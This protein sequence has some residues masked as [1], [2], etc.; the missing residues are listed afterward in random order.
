MAYLKTESDKGEGKPPRLKVEAER[1][2]QKK[3][4]AKEYECRRA[5]H[6]AEMWMHQSEELAAEKIALFKFNRRLIRNRR[7]ERI[8]WLLLS[9]SLAL[10][11]LL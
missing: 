5:R 9:I 6:D 4:E 10:A 8:G 11:H 1:A 7:I 3:C 2:L